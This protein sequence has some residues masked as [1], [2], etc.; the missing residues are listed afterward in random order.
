MKLIKF[1]PTCKTHVEVTGQKKS[2]CLEAFFGSGHTDEKQ[3][4][5]QRDMG[6]KQ[7]PV[8]WTR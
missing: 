3:K 8:D 2:D 4:H 6:R 7:R 5:L 1:C